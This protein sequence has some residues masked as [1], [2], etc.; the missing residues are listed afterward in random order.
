MRKLFL[1]KIYPNP[2]FDTLNLFLDAGRK[3]DK[4]ELAADKSRCKIM[5]NNKTHVQTPV[6]LFIT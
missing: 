4:M 3:N 1:C 6:Y 5:I 2:V